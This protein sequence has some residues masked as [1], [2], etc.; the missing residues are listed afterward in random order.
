MGRLKL[1]KKLFIDRWSGIADRIEIIYEKRTGNRR[2]R[3]I[4]RIVTRIGW[5]KLS[6]SVAGPGG[7]QAGQAMSMRSGSTAIPIDSVSQLM[8]PGLCIL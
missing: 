4:A 1:M 7:V 6:C 8:N 5:A 2:G 3:P